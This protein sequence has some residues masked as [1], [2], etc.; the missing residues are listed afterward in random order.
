VFGGVAWTSTLETFQLEFSRPTLATGVQIVSL[1]DEEIN[2]WSWIGIF[3][4]E[5]WACAAANVLGVGFVIKLLESREGKSNFSGSAGYM[6]AIWHSSSASFHNGYLRIHSTGG[7]II[8]IM[9]YFV[10]F[11]LTVSFTADLIARLGASEITPA[12][13][14]FSDLDGQT[15]GIDFS[16]RGIGESHGATE[17]LFD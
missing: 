11:I 2:I 12:V 1:G 16:N 10:Y 7:R 15:V 13:S 8:L 17:I 9:F 4:P 6:A 14:G 3:T 5:L